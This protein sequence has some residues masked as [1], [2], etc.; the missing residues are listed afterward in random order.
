ME[1]GPGKSLGTAIPMCFT[2]FA[3]TLAQEQPP[4]EGIRQILILDNAS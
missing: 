3:D 1:H 2:P 4:Q